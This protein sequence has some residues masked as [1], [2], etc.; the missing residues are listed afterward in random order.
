MMMCMMMV[1]FMVVLVVML[2][3]MVAIVMVV[4]VIRHGWRGQDQQGAQTCHEFEDLSG[5][6]GL[7]CGFHDH[8]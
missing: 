8:S 2:V 7:Q 3:M 6:C 1:V 4:L 5:G